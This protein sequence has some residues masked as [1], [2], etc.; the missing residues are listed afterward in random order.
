M[1]TKEQTSSALAA[2]RRKVNEILEQDM[3]DALSLLM[4]NWQAYKDRKGTYDRS[5]M[6]TDRAFQAIEKTMAAHDDLI[7]LQFRLGDAHH[8]V[9]R[10]SDLDELE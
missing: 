4:D 8:A 2:M 6:D 5:F 7:N 1:N 9:C 10:A 3:P